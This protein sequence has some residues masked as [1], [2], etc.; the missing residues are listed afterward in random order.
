MKRSFGSALI[1]GCL[2]F[3][4]IS[5]AADPI[6]VV[7]WDERQPAQKQ[8]YDNFLGNAIADYLKKQPG[9]DVKS[10][11]ID[12]PDQGLSK[13]TLDNCDVLIWWG[14]VRHGE[15][16]PETAKMLISRI[17]QGK[18]SLI[19]LHSAHWSMPFKEAMN[20]RA[21][22]DALASLDEKARATA[23][24]VELPA[25]GGLP[26]VTDPLTPRFE[27]KTGEDRVILTLTLPNCAF[28]T[29]RGD[30][31]PSHIRV[32]KPDHPLAKGLPAKFD[33]PQT[34][35]Y[36]SPFHVP[37]PDV[38]VFEET[39]DKG[40]SFTSGSYWKLGKGGV[41]YYRPGH[42]TFP[43]FK[44]AES[45]KFLDNAVRFLAH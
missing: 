13:S 28:P 26:K 25:P 15:I 17:K 4:S 9:L 40:E 14:H 44:Q 16:K 12:D 18:L 29:Y 1:L 36:S 7:V 11:C 2:G 33:I 24:I 21:R 20:E 22:Q 31:K 6:R 45:L 32:L 35:M 3:A 10:V 23:K 19:S 30:G 41:I 34:E 38:S 5:Y 39:W 43:V 27:R 42:E 8:A 37:E